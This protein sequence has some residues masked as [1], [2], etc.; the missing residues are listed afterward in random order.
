MSVDP[1]LNRALFCPEWCDLDDEGHALSGDDVDGSAV[2]V[3]SVERECA[4][5]GSWAVT[6]SQV[7]DKTGAVRQVPGVEARITGPEI[8]PVEARQ[9][10]QAIY[11]AADVA[12]GSQAYLRRGIGA[13]VAACM[14]DHGL[15]PATLAKRVGMSEGN[16]WRRL[17]GASGFTAE[18]IVRLARALNVEVGEL[19]T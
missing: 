15:T 13:S 9:L 5:G 17:S 12:D 11:E 3:R 18:D 7:N 2:H 19:L 6:V 16:L 14:V 1:A 4:D 10:A 8:R